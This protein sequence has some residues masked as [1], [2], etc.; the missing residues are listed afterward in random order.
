M[1]ILY[2]LHQVNLRIIKWAKAVQRKKKDKADIIQLLRGDKNQLTA[3]QKKAILDFYKPY[4]KTDPIYH[5]YY[6]EKNGIFDVRYLPDDLYYTEIQHYFNNIS[7]ALIV[8]HKGYYE[9]L[10]P[11]VRHPVTIAKRLNGYWMIN[12]Q[13][14]TIDEVVKIVCSEELVF[15]K[16]ASGS[17]GGAGVL[18]LEG[19]ELTNKN[20]VESINSLT[21]D[22]VVQKRIEQCG[23]LRKI[24]ETSVNTMRIMSLINRDGEVTILSRLLRMGVGNSRMDNAHSG[25]ISIGIEKDGRLRE[26]ALSLEGDKYYEHPNSKVVFKDIVLP[27]IK[28]IDEAIKQCALR[29][30]HFRIV[31]WDIILDSDYVPTLIEANLYDAGMDIP[32]LNNGPLFGDYTEELLS[33]VYSVKK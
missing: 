17:C 29:V 25:G 11:D 16:K 8:D 19:E 7:A 32:Q 15:I 5:Q 20:I 9:A 21:G 3:E 2:N 28:K 23:E 18:A 33:E 6:Y 1:S 27:Y 24:H 10:F 30:P 12:N 13:C 26:F 4:G 31:A 14:V 22:L